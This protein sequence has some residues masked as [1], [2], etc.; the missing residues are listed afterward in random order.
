MSPIGLNSLETKMKVSIPN[1]YDFKKPSI[2]AQTIRSL[3]NGAYFKS[4]FLTI[5]TAVWTIK[6]FLMPWYTNPVLKKYI[7]T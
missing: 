2:L 7:L 6:V 3:H 1:R 4:V 5:L